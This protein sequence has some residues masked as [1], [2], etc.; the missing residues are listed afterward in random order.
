MTSERAALGLGNPTRVGAR[1]SRP[2]VKV[3]MRRETKKKKKR[4]SCKEKKGLPFLDPDL[5]VEFPSN[6]K[7]TNKDKD[8]T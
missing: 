4:D 3:A 7:K 8:I 1:P 6:P 5:C 2:S